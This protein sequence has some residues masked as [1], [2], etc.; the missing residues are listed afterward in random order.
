MSLRLPLGT[1][2]TS[3]NVY[4]SFLLRVDDL[5]PAFASDGTLAG[6]TTGTGTSFGTKINI[7]TN[8]SG[9]YNLGTSKGTGTAYGAWAGAD[10]NV[11]DTLLLVGRYFFNGGNGTDDVC[12]LWLN[13]PR[14]SLG[15]TSPPPATIPGVGN[16]GTDLAQID[17]FFFR[18]GGSSSSPAK[19]VADEVRVGVT[20]AQVTPPAPPVLALQKPGTGLT[21]VWSTNSPVFAVQ[22]ASSLA[23]S[24]IWANESSSPTINGTNYT[25]V[26]QPTNVARFYRL[27]PLQ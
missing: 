5:G 17:R 13:P 18:S 8:G 6:F 19:L 7:R 3:G 14:G 16:G 25:F 1:N 9:G 10:F 23:P 24:A 22:S 20:W 26:V 27:A 21:L 12:D 2:L 11:G 4:F 15:A